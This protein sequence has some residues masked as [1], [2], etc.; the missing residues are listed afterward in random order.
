[1]RKLY[2]FN[3]VDI[4]VAIDVYAEIAILHSY[5]NCYNNLFSNIVVIVT[6][7]VLYAEVTILHYNMN[8]DNFRFL[9]LLLLLLLLLSL[10]L[11]MSVLK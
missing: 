2:L 9:I 1:M 5:M 4:T 10:P 7:G 11:L 8:C 6:I 3:V